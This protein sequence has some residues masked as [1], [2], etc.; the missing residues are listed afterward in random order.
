[1]ASAALVIVGIILVVIGVLGGGRLEILG[2]GV[3]SL[4][5]AGILQ[6][7]AMRRT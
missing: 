1:M 6:V 5:A 3:L 4:V 7:L 2:L